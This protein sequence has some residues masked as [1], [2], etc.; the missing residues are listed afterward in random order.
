MQPLR[1]SPVT[2]K[3]RTVLFGKPRANCHGHAVDMSALLQRAAA[4]S[5][6]TVRRT[7]VALEPERGVLAS[8][9]AAFLGFLNS[10]QETL[11]CW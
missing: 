11:S 6:M 9:L 8:M 7:A 5:R 4:S 10:P 1:W 2:Q 3:R